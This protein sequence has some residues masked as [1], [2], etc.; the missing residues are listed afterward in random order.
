MN[1]QKSSYAVTSAV[2]AKRI[3][4]RSGQGNAGQSILFVK[5]ILLIVESNA[6]KRSTSKNVEIVPCSSS[7]ECH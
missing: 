3:C 1:V 2:S 6:P 4:E 5:W 7:R